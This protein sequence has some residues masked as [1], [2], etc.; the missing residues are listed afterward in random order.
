MAAGLIIDHA[1]ILRFY[2]V[3]MT[4]AEKDLR[5]LYITASNTEEAATIGRA[6]VEDGLVACANVIGPV[7][8]IYR[9]EGAL[10]DEEEAVL[11]A[12]TTADQVE[13]V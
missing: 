10:Q 5:L 2:K 9:W 3:R 1:A 12:K 11:I 7:R 4:M 8:S 6:L 13:A